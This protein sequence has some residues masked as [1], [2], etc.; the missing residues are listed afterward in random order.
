MI[1][2]QDRVTGDFEEGVKA[3]LLEKRPAEWQPPRLENLDLNTIEKS[4]FSIER[5]L[6]DGF[7]LEVLPEAK[8]VAYGL[9]TEAHVEKVLP[10]GEEELLEVLSYEWK[11][12]HGVRE[13]VVEIMGR[14]TMLESG[15]RVW[16]DKGAT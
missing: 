14:K 1:D 12:K 11:G 8:S 2:I 7:T 3:L 9:P 5:S 16:R 6:P 13:R 10:L 4:F 15:M